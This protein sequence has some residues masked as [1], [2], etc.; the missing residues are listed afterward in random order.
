MSFEIKFTQT[1]ANHIRALRKF[2]QQLIL[3]AIEEQLVS[4]PHQETR[5]RKRLGNN[6]ISDWELRVDKY[7]IFYDLELTEEKHVVKIKAVG[8][9][10]H[11]TLYI[12]GKETKL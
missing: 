1:A 10:V 5:N 12:G 6:D 7:R 4:E 2:E 8:Y 3:D 9:K 11:N